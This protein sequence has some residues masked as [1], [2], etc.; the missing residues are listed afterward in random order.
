MEGGVAGGCSVIYGYQRESSKGKEL[1]L[2]VDQL[3][4]QEG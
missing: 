3:G 1:T 4:Y 2:K